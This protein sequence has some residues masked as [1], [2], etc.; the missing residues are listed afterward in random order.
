MALSQYYEVMDHAGYGVDMLRREIAMGCYWLCLSQVKD[1]EFDASASVSS[2]DTLGYCPFV[3]PLACYGQ[4][5]A[6]RPPQSHTFCFQCQ[7]SDKE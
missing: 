5:H 6:I 3:V 4:G 1:K 7:A 2:D